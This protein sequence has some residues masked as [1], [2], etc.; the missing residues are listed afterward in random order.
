MN[1][2]IEIKIKMEDGKEVILKDKEARELFLKL[3]EIYEVDKA[4]E[5]VPYYPYIPPIITPSIPYDPNRIWYSSDSTL[6]VKL[7]NY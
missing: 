3:S 1:V 5:Y 7:G 4:K 2:S 6:S